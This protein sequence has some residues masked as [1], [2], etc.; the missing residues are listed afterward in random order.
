MP[1]VPSAQANKKE[2]GHALPDPG[3]GA[4]EEKSKENQGEKYKEAQRT[5]SACMF[6]P[7]RGSITF[8]RELPMPGML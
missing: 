6:M 4:S 8:M 3:S 5:L 1:K 2:S 7:G